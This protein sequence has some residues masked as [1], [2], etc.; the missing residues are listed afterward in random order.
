[1]SDE[2]RITTKRCQCCGR[3]LPVSKFK[4]NIKSKDGYA[5][6][7]NDCKATNDGRNPKLL[8]FTPRELLDELKARGYH[9]TITYIQK[10]IINI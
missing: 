5:K 10:H 4:R 9:G 3:E 1:M 2:N 8:S 6:I 7:C